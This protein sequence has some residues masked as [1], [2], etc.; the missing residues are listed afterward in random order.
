MENIE[1]QKIVDGSTLTVSLK[2]RL[3]TANSGEVSQ[4]L[5]G[6]LNGVKQL[7]LDFTD[8]VYISSSG[9]RILLQLVK[10]LKGQ[11]G[12]L[13]VRHVSKEIMDVFKMTGFSSLLKIFFFVSRF[14]LRHSSAI[15]AQSYVKNLN[16]ASLFKENSK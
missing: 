4:D 14:H 9:L 16:Y 6:S 15:S 3:D 2:G 11:Q 10:Q 7:V 5:L 8:L 13:I 1:L 12:E